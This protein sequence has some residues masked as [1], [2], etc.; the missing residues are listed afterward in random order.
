MPVPDSQVPVEETEVVEE[1]A[2]SNPSVPATPEPTSVETTASG[3]TLE[4]LAMHNT[5]EDCWVGYKGNVYD[6]TEWLPKHPGGVTRIS[7]HCGTA[8]EFEEA[9]TR[10][11]RGQQES[12]LEREAQKIGAL[13]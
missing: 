11:H 6:V 5:K 7:Q 2:P 12:R 9:F 3:I 10:K 4:E 13:A 8:A 1:A